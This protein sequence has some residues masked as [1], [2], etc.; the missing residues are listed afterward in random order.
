[1]KQ[2]VDIKNSKLITDGLLGYKGFKT[3]R[4]MEH[5]SCHTKYRL[6][7]QS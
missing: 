4:V 3:A 6:V 1:M 5:K 7:Y 2:N